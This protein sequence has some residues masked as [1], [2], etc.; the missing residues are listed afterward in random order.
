MTIS[1]IVTIKNRLEH[2]K[3]IFSSLI[4][5]RL[6]LVNYELIIVNYHSNDNLNYFLKNELILHRDI[7]SP[8]LKCI[9][10]VTLNNDLKFNPRKAKNL[11][12]KVSEG[13]LIAFTDADVFLSMD[14][15]N[16]WKDFVKQGEYFI[17][18]RFKGDV[19]MGIEPTRITSEVNYGNCIVPKKDFYEIQGWD[20]SIS[21]YGGDDDDFYHRFKLKGLYE[22]NPKNYIEAKQYSIL[23]DDEL[24][25]NELE[26]PTRCDK[27]K[28]FEDI[29]SNKNFLSKESNFL[30]TFNN[31]TNECLYVNTRYN[32]NNNQL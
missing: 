5:Q 4:T 1:L 32:N 7:F 21:N 6:D 12:A 28:R 27:I 26:D 22:I 15:L 17:A 13:D 30:K 11:G 8:E 25:L 18:T 19:G 3:K 14:Y 24:R 10:I 16:Y 2:F 29:Y 23:H 9:K 20:E 31:Y